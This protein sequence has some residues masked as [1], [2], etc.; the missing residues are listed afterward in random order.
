[1]QKSFLSV[2]LVL[3]L[4]GVG[5]VVGC[6][7]GVPAVPVCSTTVCAAG[8]VCNPTSGACETPPSRCSATSCASPLV[9][10]GATGFCGFPLGDLI[11]RAGRPLINHMLSNPFDLLT[12]GGQ[13]Q[14]GTV[15]RETYNKDKF[16]PWS[17]WAPF[18]AQTLALYDGLDGVCGHPYAPTALGA[19]RF[20]TLA[21]LLAADAILI[22]TSKTVCAAYMSVEANA[23]AGRASTDCGG[24]KVDYDVVDATMSVIVGSPAPDTVTSTYALAPTFPY[25]Q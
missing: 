22:D 5:L 8:Q 21:S 24:R 17:S 6:G 1:M 15:T 11:D 10:D 2:P 4:G 7:S 12:I 25:F 16:F 14:T 19:T 20:S 13:V 3:G 23:L 18:F 9:C